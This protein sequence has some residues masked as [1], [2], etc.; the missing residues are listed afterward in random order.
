[1]NNNIIKYYRRLKDSIPLQIRLIPFKLWRS[2]FVCTFKEFFGVRCHD[3]F[4]VRKYLAGKYQVI[5]GLFKGMRYL[6]ISHCSALIPKLVGTYE[7]EISGWLKDSKKYLNIIN[8]GSAE[9]YYAVGLALKNAATNV[10]AVDIS[11]NARK[12][13]KK[14][15]KLNRVKNVHVKS[16]LTKED[17]KIMRGGLIV[18]DIEG[19]EVEIINPQRN[20]D[21]L[22]YDY[23]IECHDF[24]RPSTSILINRFRKSHIVDLVLKKDCCPEDYPHLKRYPEEVVKHLVYEGR[25]GAG[26]MVWIRLTRDKKHGTKTGN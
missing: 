6:N 3:D 18:S 12:M 4:Y 21:L 2:Y 26:R 15:I 7:E 24:I 20:R 25:E 14:L 1:M 11:P 10:L 13:C 19:D 22:D 23:I 16:F 17:F 8:L 9:G 5:W